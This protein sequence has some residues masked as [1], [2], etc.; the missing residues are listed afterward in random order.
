MART[1]K[2]H[3]TARLHTDG[4]EEAEINPSVPQQQKQPDATEGNVIADYYPY[5]RMMG[6][7][8]KISQIAQDEKGGK[9]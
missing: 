6:Q 3:L 1:V 8:T 7:K 2:G 5:V 4:A 9:L